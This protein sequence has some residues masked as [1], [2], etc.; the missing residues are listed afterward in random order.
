MKPVILKNQGRGAF[1]AYSP[2]PRPIGEPVTNVRT[3]I[4]LVPVTDG[5]KM[6][7]WEATPG[8]W[9]RVI[10]KREFSYFFEG[11]CT[12]TPEATGETIEIEAGDSVWLPENSLGV[13]DIIELTKKAFVIIG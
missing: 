3:A 13:W 9:H 7:I 12:F 8:T 10:T 4:G 1:A 6:G 11:R 5:I 2:V